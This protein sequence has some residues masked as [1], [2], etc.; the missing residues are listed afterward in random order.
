MTLHMP[1]PCP[2]W[3]ALASA[4]LC[5]AT[6]HAFAA[7]PVTPAAPVTYPAKPIR[8]VVPFAPGGGTDIM[9]RAIGVRYTEAWG[10][11]VIV[12][13]RAGGGGNIGTDI[14]AKAPADGH[15]LLFNTNATIVINP[16]LGKISFDPLKDFAPVTQAAV[17]PFALLL[18][19]SVPAKSVAELLSLIRAKPGEFNYGSSG[20]GGGAHLAGESLRT[21]AKLN[22]THVPYKGAAPALVALIGGEVKFMFVSILTAT[23]LIES[24]KVR[25]IGVSSKKRS[26]AL[27]NVPAVAESPGLAGFESDLWYGM[28]APA[29]TSPGIIDKLY[30][31]TRRMLLLPEV[32]NRFEPSGTSIVGNSPAE[33]EKVIKDDFARWGTVIKAA[34][35]KVE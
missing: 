31:E 29:K 25:V 30:Q 5:I 12:D 35:I 28:L 33:F 2:L 11:P 13:N 24:G 18:H 4:M 23:P 3:R 27:P 34:G 6:Q 8:I 9:A 16:H 22:M 20:N 15:T 14:V 1:N 7:A 10:Q 17:L 21:M 19:P 26:P 32:R